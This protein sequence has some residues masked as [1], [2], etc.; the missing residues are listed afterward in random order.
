ME[1]L[2]SMAAPWPVM[3]RSLSRSAQPLAG[4][5][6]EVDARGCAAGKQHPVRQRSTS[7][8][9]RRDRSGRRWGRLAVR[10]AAA[11]GASATRS[12]LVPHSWPVVKGGHDAFRRHVGLDLRHRA[13]Q[14]H[15]QEAG[16]NLFRPPHV[17]TLPD[18]D[19][20]PMTGQPVP[21]APAPCGRWWGER[22][23]T[24]RPLLPLAYRSGDAVPVRH[25]V[26]E[27]TSP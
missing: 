22:P 7:S 27:R 5:D 10:I 26:R 6:A 3:D 23:V 21:P 4:P 11:S 2:C 16:A 1:H 19:A 17:P 12:S 8:R 24:A 25:P 14:R 9:H 13:P 20:G 15:G 18:P